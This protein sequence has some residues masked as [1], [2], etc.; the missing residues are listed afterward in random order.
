MA[1]IFFSLVDLLFLSLFLSKV[2]Q[3]CPSQQSKK[4]KP[5]GHQA[6]RRTS[7]QTQR[8]FCEAVGRKKTST[9]KVAARRKK[10]EN[11]TESGREKKKITAEEKL[12]SD[13]N[14]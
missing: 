1:G 5:S 13:A 11:E 12:K 7:K 9:R 14:S 8:T 6:V 4:G 10:D 3:K 2:C